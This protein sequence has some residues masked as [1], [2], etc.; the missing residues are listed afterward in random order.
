ML[1]GEYTQLVK[2]L[3][4]DKLLE[5][6]KLYFT[7]KYQGDSCRI[8]ECSWSNTYILTISRDGREFDRFVYISDITNDFE[9]FITDHIQEIAASSE[10][11]LFRKLECICLSKINNKN[12]IIESSDIEYGITLDIADPEVLGEVIESHKALKDFL[13]IPTSKDSHHSIKFNRQNKI[14]YDLFSIG[15]KIADIKNSF[16]GSYIQYYLLEKGSLSHDDLKATLYKPLPNLS[17]QAFNDAISRN[18]ESGIISK[19]NEKYTL[20]PEYKVQLEEMQAITDATEKRLLRQF[21]EC[22]NEYGIQNQSQNILDTI[23]ELYKDQ[24]NSELAIIGHNE[25]LG[26]QDKNLINK[27]FDSLIQKGIDKRN[28][29]TIIQKI[30][31]IISDSE[32]LNKVSATTL[33]TGLFN[34]NSLEDY[35][36]TQ[37]RIV[38]LDSQVLFQ[39]LCVDYKDVNYKDSLYEAGKILYNQ[40]D[41]FQDYVSLFTTPD[42]IQEISNHL[43][44]AYN[45]KQFIELPYIQDFGP[46]KNIFY[47]FYLYLKNEDDTKYLDYEDYL[48]DLLNTNDPLPGD[49]FSFVKQTNRLII[50][51]LDMIDIHIRHIDTPAD[52]SSLK[53]DYDFLL[54]EHPKGNKA[55]ENDIICMYYLSDQTNFINPE[56]NLSE[57][58]YLITL[59]TTLAPMRKKLVENYQRTYWY[60][61]SPLRFANK[62]SIMNLKLDSKNINFDIICMAETNFKASYN[63][64]SMLDIMSMFFQNNDIKNKKLPRMLAKMKA[65]EQ[66]DDSLRQ[67][68]EKNNN[69]LPIDVVL[70]NIHRHYRQ[71]GRSHLS[72]ISKLFETDELSEQIVD[73]LKKG[74]VSISYKNKMDDQIYTELDKLIERYNIH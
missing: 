62:L 7:R 57:E 22:L 55:R 32:Y 36:G 33:F 56:T 39:L 27:L 73:L 69:N 43:Y 40:L 44:E 28:I 65:N 3:S 45:L 31:N 34:S 19:E 12:S 20:S 15:N 63:T 58:P 48:Q 25:E 41:E 50:D 21:E 14:L 42:Y 17:D 23:L 74:C 24:S 1:A 9:S 49:Y 72:L 6:A 35:L 8:R 53:R 59:D 54:G 4:G 61:Y 13:T 66:K 2:D 18:I 26:A 16:I 51:I 71:Q 60:I 52:F 70:N 64:I 47:N 5:F 67:Y 68:S 10:N 38:F 46:S 11:K 30:L 29:N 37:K